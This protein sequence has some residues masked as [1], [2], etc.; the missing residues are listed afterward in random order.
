VTDESGGH[1]PEA[2]AEVGFRV[3]WFHPERP[4]AGTT[5]RRQQVPQAGP[6]EGAEDAASH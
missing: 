6:G 3:N 2:S 1:D 4:V 5:F